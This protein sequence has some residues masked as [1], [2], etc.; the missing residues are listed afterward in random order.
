MGSDVGRESLVR[1]IRNLLP[2]DFE[3]IVGEL[4]DPWVERLRAQGIDRAQSGFGVLLKARWQ[5]F[6][7][8][9]RWEL[10]LAIGASAARRAADDPDSTGIA[11]VAATFAELAAEER[12]GQ[13]TGPDPGVLAELLSA[14]SGAADQAVAA[15]GR[16]LEQG[17]ACPEDLPRAIREYNDTLAEAQALLAARG[18]RP[19]PAGRSAVLA[20]LEE[21]A[22]TAE[23]EPFRQAV[24]ELARVEGDLPLLR[25][26]R[27]RAGELLEATPAE[28]TDDQVRLAQ[29]L[30]AVVEL[31]RS[32]VGGGTPA[33]LLAVSA[34]AQALL[35]AELHGLVILA[36]SRSL[37]F[38]PTS[39]PGPGFDPDQ[40]DAAVA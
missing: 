30:A 29:G 25:D 38:R 17:R 5:N 28:W 10:A 31:R 24:A 3:A 39:R 4:P 26:V 19:V 14:T 36:A 33:A 9:L 11:E 18:I 35:P 12:P 20:A 23:R 2:R 1:A 15:A 37:V 21:L 27:E 34:R 7:S 6:P 40:V 13:L 32:T 8:G 16:A 22:A